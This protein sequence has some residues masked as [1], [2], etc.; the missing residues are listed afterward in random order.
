MNHFKYFTFLL[1][2]LVSLG[3]KSQLGLSP[4][5]GYVEV[6]G[7]KIWYKVLGEGRSTPLLLMHGGPGGTHR[8]FYELEPLSKERPII[9]FDQL[10]TGRSGYHTD[11]ALLKVDKFVEQVHQLKKH[12]KLDKYYILGHSWGAALELEFY[13]KHPEGIEGII[14]SSPYVSTPIWT[15]DADTLIMSLP[16]SV[17]TYIA[18]A[19]ESG[20]YASKEY[21]YANDLYWSKFGLRSE[22][23]QHPLDTVPAPG[24]SFIYNYMWGPSE[25]TSTGTLKNYNNVE[26]LDDVKV[27]VLFVT[28]EYDEARPETVKSFHRMIPGSQ[29]AMI[30]NAGHSTARDNSEQYIE[31]I[32]AFMNG[33]EE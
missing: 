32:K 31:V 28:G 3:C 33:L 1:L 20:D 4:H 14:F 6:E 22:F 15:A 17:Q 23:K 11:T 10:G 26:A 8:Y 18:E 19:E 5:E 30:E 2:L 7:G 9:L 16:D 21:Q 24:N 13:Q 27:P 25:F 29:F 12:L